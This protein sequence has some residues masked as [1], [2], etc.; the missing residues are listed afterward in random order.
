MYD[1]TTP[2]PAHIAGQQRFSVNANGTTYP[3]TPL[4]ISHQPTS[5]TMQLD[6]HQA[7]AEERVQTT[8]GVL[9]IRG[10][11]IPCPAILPLHSTL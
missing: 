1:I 4:R 8:E 5:N 6:S 3:L 2:A 11:C 7:G 10:G 9:R